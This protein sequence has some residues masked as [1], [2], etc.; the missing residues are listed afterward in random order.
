MTTAVPD[1]LIPAA[2]PRTLRFMVWNLL[3]GGVDRESE[4]RLTDQL[5][6]IAA[7]APDVLC[8][9]EATFWSQHEQRLLRLATGTLGMKVATLAKTRVGDGKN[10]TALLYNP[11]S[12]RLVHW[13]LRGVGVFHHALIRARFRPKAAGDDPAADF[14]VF[15]THLNPF[16]GEARLNEVRGWLT[17]SGGAFPGMPSRAVAIGDFNTP[18]RE[19]D[20]WAA[21]PRNLHSCYRLVLPD[22]SFGDTDQRAI[23]VLLNSGWQDP[24]HVLGIPRPPTVG[25]YYVNERVPWAIDRGLTVGME[26]VTVWTHP[27]DESFHLS[28]HL[29]HF[30]DL[31]LAA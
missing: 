22:G 27:F 8:L 16:N 14:T 10:A 7:C 20:S 17:D 12:V 6:L 13:Q 30:M 24:H 4:A 1:V 25:H 23:R 26:P 21:V 31:H 3:N 2:P 29:P 28:D 19:P 15:S 11:A 18:D 9:P 5:H